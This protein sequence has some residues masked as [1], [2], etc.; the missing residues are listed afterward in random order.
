[1]LTFLETLGECI[2]PRIVIVVDAVVVVLGNF[3]F[4]FNFPTPRPVF[5]L[6]SNRYCLLLEPG[7]KGIYN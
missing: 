3:Y 1:M 2:S 4:D 6:L 5:L 7:N